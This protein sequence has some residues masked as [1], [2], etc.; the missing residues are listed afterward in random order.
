MGVSVANDLVG[1]TEPTQLLAFL[2][3]SSLMSSASQPKTHAELA[4]NFA[5]FCA[6]QRASPSAPSAIDP[7]TP[8]LANTPSKVV[9]P[10]PLSPSAA[11]P[12]KQQK[13]G[14]PRA[15]SADPPS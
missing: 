13:S 11:P 9:P 5:A 14:T 2:L 4:A 10:H 6:S 15:P 8:S 7:G 1:E 3:P 12:A